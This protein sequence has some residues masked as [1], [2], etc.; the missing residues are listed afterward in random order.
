MLEKIFGCALMTKLCSIL[1]MDMDFNTTNK[2]IYGQQ[3]IHQ[4]RNDKL[5]P[6]E[7]YSKKNQPADNGTLAKV[8]YYNIVR[9]TWLHAGICLVDAGNCYDQIAHPIAKLVFQALGVPQEV[10]VSL[11][12]T[13]QDIKFFLRTGFGDSKVYAD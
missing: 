13:I 8:L 7:I 6:E 1:L 4:V 12:S 2:I 11:L 9:Q 5:I 3:M 10:V